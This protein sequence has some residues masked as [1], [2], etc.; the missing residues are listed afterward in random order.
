MESLQSGYKP[1]L[2]MIFASLG[3]IHAERHH[4]TKRKVDLDEAIWATKFALSISSAEHPLTAILLGNLA[5]ELW[6]RYR[7]SGCED[8]LQQALDYGFRALESVPQESSHQAA[9]LGTLGAIRASLYNCR[10]DF[11]D[12]QEA[13]SITQKSIDMATR[14]AGTA[15]MISF[16]NLGA[17]LWTQH[18]LAG[19][20]DDMDNSVVSFAKAL[21][22]ATNETV[23]RVTC[24]INSAHVLTQRYHRTGQ[25]Q[26]L[27]C[28]LENAKE[29]MRLD[30]QNNDL[31]TLL[32]C[33]DRF[34]DR[35]RE[36]TSSLHWFQSRGHANTNRK[37]WAPLI[38][39]G[40]FI[41]IVTMYAYH[42]RTEILLSIVAFP[43]GII[44]HWMASARPTTAQE[45]KSMQDYYTP[46]LSMRGLLNSRGRSHQYTPKLLAVPLMPVPFASSLRDIHAPDFSAYASS[47]YHQR[48]QSLQ[49]VKSER[50][51]RSRS[52]A[53]YRRD[54]DERVFEGRHSGHRRASS[55]RIH[56]GTPTMGNVTPSGFVSPRSQNNSSPSTLRNV[57]P[58]VEIELS[59]NVMGLSRRQGEAYVVSFRPEVGYANINR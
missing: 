19:R 20:G 31:A 17:Y 1:N 7:S 9:V 28:A 13:I 50:K 58:Q 35:R 43:I 57:R 56:Q 53:G 27:G 10:G 41:F 29:A 16:N 38:L 47:L 48:R 15:P 6:R 59:R 46:I 51:V 33:L 3:E 36:S 54:G 37:L 8:D 14:C 4:R 49:S 44:Y 22:C 34:L 18:C 55:S 24:L 21:E 25:L 2:V 12:L 30:P 45:E 32:K 26:D 40:V 11:R 42:L 5:N 23:D 52:P 39:L